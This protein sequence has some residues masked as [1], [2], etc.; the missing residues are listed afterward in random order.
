MD[1]GL[2]ILKQDAATTTR[3]MRNELCVDGNPLNL[4]EGLSTR[5]T[6]LKGTDGDA[7]SYRCGKSIYGQTILPCELCVTIDAEV[8][9][10]GHGKWWLDGNRG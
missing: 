1:T 9:A 8:E 5:G 7:K 4:V 10:P 3:N 2:T 6:V